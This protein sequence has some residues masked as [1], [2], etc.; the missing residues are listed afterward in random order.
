MCELLKIQ[1][2][3]DFKLLEKQLTERWLE[4][5]K[6]SNAFRY[7]LNVE[8][9]KILDGNLHFLMTVSCVVKSLNYSNKCSNTCHIFVSIHSS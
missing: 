3:S 9:Q 5:E 2:L 6:N 7:K 8:K 1:K 4:L